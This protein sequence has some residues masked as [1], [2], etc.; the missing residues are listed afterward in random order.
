MKR[1]I[2]CCGV[3]AACAMAEP[4]TWDK[5]VQSAVE[6]PVLQA[7]SKK[8]SAITN[9]SGLKLWDDLQFEYTLDGFGLMEHDFELKLKPKAFGEGA[10]DDAYWKSQ[11]DY[12][13]AQ[14][15]VDRADVLYERYEHALRYV[16][17]LKIRQLHTQ[18]MQICSDRIEVLHAQSGSETFRLQDLV[19]ALEDRSTIEGELIGDSAQ[20]NDSKMKLLSWVSGIDSVS[21]D[22]NFL[23]TVEELKAIL[24]G[25]AFDSEKYAEVAK[26]KAKWQVYE[27]RADQESAGDRNYIS[28]VSVG[29]KYVY[30][31]YKYKWV[32]VGYNSETK[33]TDQEWQ[34][35]R[36]DDD[37]RTQDKFYASVSVRLPFFSSSNST[38]LKRQIDVLE[39]ER[40]YQ[41]TKRDISQKV[42]RR[43]EEI[44][45]LIA[46]RDVQKRFVDQVDEGSLFEDFAAKA[47]NDP[48][49]LLR[50][51]ESA[52]ES[53][54][55]IV[56]LDSDI[57]TVYLNLLY[58]M[59]ALGRT[60]V[61]NHF[62]AGPAR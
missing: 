55:K 42:T 7:S 48:L 1:M 24:N 50:A 26:A 62:K 59:G 30:G 29:Y 46:Q 60:D 36:T 52:V 9:R 45:G 25:M 41:A 20:I 53:Q 37:R 54:L 43:R 40:D 13:K 14:E 35:T 17:R 57:F 11:G 22:T 6:D 34:L 33:T 8:E 49:L 2:V 38:N 27:K 21:L 10:A 12:Q 58:E 39:S 23:P 5:L 18:L 16:T 61:D 15:S 19:T 47:G 3:L 31:K 44:L 56:K 51:R 32:D 28:Q 4:L